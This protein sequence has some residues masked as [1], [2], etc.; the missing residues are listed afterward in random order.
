MP[1]ASTRV[2]TLPP[3]SV[4]TFSASEEKN[5]VITSH[6]F[7]ESSATSPDSRLLL[8]SVGARIHLTIGPAG[9]I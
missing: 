6:S 5:D 7:L 1:T 2:Q 3:P 8:L 4:A 9:F